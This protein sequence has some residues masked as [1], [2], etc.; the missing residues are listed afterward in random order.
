MAGNFTAFLPLEGLPFPG[1]VNVNHVK[2]LTALAAV[3]AV[4]IILNALSQLV[5]AL[6][7]DGIYL[8]YRFLVSAS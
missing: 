8:I 1:C 3:P 5:R 4:A 6:R 2:L 7:P